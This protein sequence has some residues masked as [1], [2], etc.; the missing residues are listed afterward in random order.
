MQTTLCSF[1]TSFHL[2]F[3][4]CTY[5]T[6]LDLLFNHFSPG[7]LYPLPNPHFLQFGTATFQLTTARSC[8]AAPKQNFLPINR[9]LFWRHLITSALIFC[10]IKEK[11]TCGRDACAAHPKTIMVKNGQFPRR[12]PRQQHPEIQNNK[13]TVQPVSASTEP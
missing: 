11:N 4:T 3:P 8:N 13:K 12:G 5:S 1:F 2:K 10:A 6:Q 7:R 9:A